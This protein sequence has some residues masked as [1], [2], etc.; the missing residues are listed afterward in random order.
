[1]RIGD[2]LKL[3][4]TLKGENA[5]LHTKPRSTPSWI[6]ASYAT[7]PRQMSGGQKQRASGAPRT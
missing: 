2:Q 6:E 7:H 1:V 4:A 3:A 5:R